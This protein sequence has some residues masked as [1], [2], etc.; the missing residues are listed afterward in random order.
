MHTEAL[1]IVNKIQYKIN[2]I[3][4]QPNAY[5]NREYHLVSD[6]YFDKS[7]IEN[8]KSMQSKYCI[9]EME[10]EIDT[11][12]NQQSICAAIHT[13]TSSQV[14]IDIYK[15]QKSTCY[16]VKEQISKPM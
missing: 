2:M 11:T 10:L 6:L 1:D 14:Y 4:N 12:A 8:L 7:K 15:N 13:I 5:F 9:I 16:R 3:N